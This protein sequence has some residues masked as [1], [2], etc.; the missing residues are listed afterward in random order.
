M[1]KIIST[2]TAPATRMWC[3]NVMAAVMAV[4][5]VKGIIDG[6]EAA[7]ILAVGA[8]LFAVASVN[9]P[10]PEKNYEGKHEA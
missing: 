1:E 9:T 7:A 2:L 5:T 8:A 4:L 6:D 3:Y 10:R